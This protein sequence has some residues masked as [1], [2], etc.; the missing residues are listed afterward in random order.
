MPFEEHRTL[1]VST[2]Q[3]STVVAQAALARPSSDIPLRY[4]PR[5][6]RL[7][8]FCLSLCPDITPVLNDLVVVHLVFSTFHTDPSIIL[9]TKASKAPPCHDNFLPQPTLMSICIISVSHCFPALL[10]AIEVSIWH[11]T[12]DSGYE[13]AESD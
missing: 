3:N 2:F 7:V 9:Q 10:F 5:C 12:T 11:H 8:P 13:V 4:S 1:Q 6:N